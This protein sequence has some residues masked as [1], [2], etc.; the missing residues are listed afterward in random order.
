MNLLLIEDNKEIADIIFDYFELKGIE[1]DYAH[2]GL[3]GFELAKQQE[4]DLIILDVMLPKMDGY[5]VCQKLREEGIQTPVLMLTARDSRDD[6]LT[7]FNQGADDYLV[8]PFDLDILE[9]RIHALIRRHKGDIA[10]TQLCY[11]ELVLDLK[12]HTVQR[13]NQR[14]NLNPV[15]YI[16]LKTL[17]QQAPAVVSRQ[18]L[19]TAI[20]GKDEPD[21][22]LLRNHI[23]Q[24]R[25]LIDKP[26]ASACI[27][28][29]P[30][31]GYQIML[32]DEDGL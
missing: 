25:N 28:T 4:Y 6:I 27:H 21:S 16:L 10:N 7:G 19:I 13:Q 18:Q 24:L 26:F 20:W 1:L 30:K 8:K 12:Q 11:K 3:Q 17:I 23:Y 14:F 5:S 2:Q 22:D 29:V 31:T 15:Q 32:P 9:A